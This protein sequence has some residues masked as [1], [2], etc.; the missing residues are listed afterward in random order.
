MASARNA[1]SWC[2]MANRTGRGTFQ[3]RLA[4]LLWVNQ[5]RYSAKIA[6]ALFTLRGGSVTQDT[7]ASKT[8]AMKVTRNQLKGEALRER[9]RQVAG[10]LRHARQSG[11]R[12]TEFSVMAQ[13]W[14]GALPA[15]TPS[16]EPG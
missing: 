7:V 3:R 4:A 15:A 13:F 16:P 11:V 1:D 5:S 12:G 9:N 2:M 14:L 10:L 6:Q 8:P